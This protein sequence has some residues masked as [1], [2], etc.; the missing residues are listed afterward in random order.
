MCHNLLFPYKNQVVPM[1]NLWE[2][3]NFGSNGLIGNNASIIS[4]AN[5]H[6][7]ID[8]IDTVNM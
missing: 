7:L 5:T 2:S 4:N 8:Y 3:Q 6:N 1:L